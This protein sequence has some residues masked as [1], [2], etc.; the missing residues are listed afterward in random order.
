MSAI[1]QLRPNTSETPDPAVL[2]AA[3][4][5]LPES[6]AIVASGMVVYAN[7]AW[8]RMFEG[9]DSSRHFLSLLAESQLSDPASEDQR[10][11]DR[12]TESRND[13]RKEGD[14]IPGPEIQLVHNRGDGTRLY[15]EV[16]RAGF[17][18]RSRELQVVHAR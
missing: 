7:P 2:L 9:V 12:K 15:L 10:K 16:T 8:H 13:D 14:G 4:Q 11:K 1:A 18:S 5:A 6:V 3:I 17:H